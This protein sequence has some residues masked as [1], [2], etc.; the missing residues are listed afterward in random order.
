M[1]VGGG[2]G[3]VTGRSG[4]AGDGV[5]VGSVRGSGA[6]R[7]RRRVRP[8]PQPPD[9]QHAE[10]PTADATSAPTT[11][12]AS[13]QRRV[14]A[15]PRRPR[16]PRGRRRAPP[17]RGHVVRRAVRAGRVRRGRGGALGCVRGEERAQLRAGVVGASKDRTGSEAEAGSARRAR[18]DGG[19]SQAW[20]WGA[21]QEAAAL[22]SEEAA[23]AAAREAHFRGLDQQALAANLVWAQQRRGGGLSSSSGEQQRA[24][25]GPNSAISAPGPPAKT[26]N[27]QKLDIRSP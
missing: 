5:G 14:A 10:S 24:P 15:P 9:Q 18:E 2:V 27:S 22:A 26:T 17:R 4:D 16:P 23:A 12:P 3:G 6:G 19:A 1:V 13:P 20:R 11:R 25:D 21:A 8:P 7:S